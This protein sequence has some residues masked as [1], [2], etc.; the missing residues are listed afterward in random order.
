M[1]LVEKNQG[2]QSSGLS[3]EEKELSLTRSQQV[4]TAMFKDVLTQDQ[5][6]A[7]EKYLADQA[8]IKAEQPITVPKEKKI[9]TA[10]PAQIEEINN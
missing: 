5:F 9:T 1:G 2:I 4:K 6:I 7:Y 10:E 8:K 3:S